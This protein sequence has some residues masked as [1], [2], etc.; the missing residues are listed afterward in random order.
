MIYESKWLYDIT[1]V[2][3]SFGLLIPEV[4]KRVSRTAN[5]RSLIL[6]LLL[7]IITPGFSQDNRQPG[8]GL[9][10][11]IVPPKSD[12]QT[13]TRRILST[14]E[15]KLTPGDAYELIVILDKSGS[16]ASVA[17]DAIGSFNTFLAEQKKVKN[18]E[19][20]LTLTLFDTA[21]NVVH[22]GVALPDVPDLD[23]NTYR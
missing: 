14:T 16:M 7:I 13:I 17:N 4:M 20:K 9:Q 18:G 8:F 22:N 15:Y 12:P 6:S 19:A 5:L 11:G 23:R 21:Y 2:A 10:P 1:V 3:L